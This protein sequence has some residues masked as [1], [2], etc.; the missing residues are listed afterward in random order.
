MANAVAPDPVDVLRSELVD[1]VQPDKL[2]SIELPI[3]LRAVC[4]YEVTKALSNVA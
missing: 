1:T 2:A 3:W 4:R